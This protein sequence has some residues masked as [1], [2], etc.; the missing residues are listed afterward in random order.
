MVLD[1]NGAVKT[2]EEFAEFI[3]N[4]EGDLAFVIG[5]P[6]GILKELKKKSRPAFLPCQ[7]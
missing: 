6:N 3:K 5:G 2:S 4:F 7:K 1:E